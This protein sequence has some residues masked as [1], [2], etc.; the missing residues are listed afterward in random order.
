MGS[1]KYHGRRLG[2]VPKKTGRLTGRG[3]AEIVNLLECKLAWYGFRSVEIGPFVKVN[4]HTISIDL[5]QR[6]ACWVASRSTVSRAPSR[7]QLGTSSLLVPTNGG[8]I[9]PWEVIW[10]LF[11][12]GSGT[13]RKPYGRRGCVER[14]LSLRAGATRP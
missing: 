1:M 5:S 14:T 11:V 13:L 8:A 2:D 3:L 7:G 10:M 9:R 4:R 6:G 12:S